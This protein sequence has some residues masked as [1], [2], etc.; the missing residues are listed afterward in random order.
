VTQ[1]ERAIADLHD[2]RKAI[3]EVFAPIPDSAL[4]WLK[5]GDDYALGGIVIHLIQSLD[6]Y[7]GTL[8][9]LHAAGYRDTAGP[10][11]DESVVDA[12][13]AHA[14]LGLA[15]RE[16]RPKFEEMAEKQETLGR[17]ASRADDEQF[18][19]LVG[20]RYPGDDVPHVRDLFAQW[21]TAR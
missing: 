7:I 5:P 18:T 4:A 2:A 16:R 20:V 13:L 12:G 21:Q 15:P 8:E 14:R 10:A 1:K 6:G 17:L 11:E 19:R 9:A 3:D